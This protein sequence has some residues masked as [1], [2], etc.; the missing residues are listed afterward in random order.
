MKQDRTEEELQPKAR[1]RASGALLLGALRD[2]VALAEAS[3]ASVDAPPARREGVRSARR[4]LKAVRV[5]ADAPP[6]SAR[7]NASFVP[8]VT[9]KGSEILMFGGECTDVATD[10]VYVYNDLYRF[11]PAAG[12]TSGGKWTRVVS[13]KGP[14]ARCA[15]QAWLHKGCMYVWGGEFCSP[16]LEKFL[17][18]R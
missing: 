6:P 15:H 12:G 17:H 9:P 11:A 16:N 3:L 5:E 18:F 13:P 8:H 10:K 1:A 14:T 7:V 2:A 4:E